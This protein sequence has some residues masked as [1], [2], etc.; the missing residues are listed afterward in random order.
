MVVAY[1]P[2]AGFL[3][4]AGN[5]HVAGEREQ[6]LTKGFPGD[7]QTRTPA[8]ISY[9]GIWEHRVS[10]KIFPGTPL[11]QQHNQLVCR[12][13]SDDAIKWEGGIYFSPNPDLIESGVGA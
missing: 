7:R 2:V 4:V 12:F 11:Q 3:R 1:Q 5:I 9:T 6:P 13:K 8:F 10:G